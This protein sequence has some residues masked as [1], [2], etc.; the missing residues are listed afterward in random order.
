MAER[1]DLG[2]IKDVL[3]T[4]FKRYAKRFTQEVVEEIEQAYEEVYE[5]FMKSY[6]NWAK[7]SGKDYDKTRF[8]LKASNVYNDIGNGRG[9]QI[10]TSENDLFK[11]G[12]NVDSNNIRGEIFSRWGENK[13]E[14]YDKNAV[15]EMMF[16]HGI[17]GYNKKIVS[18]KWYITKES[19]RKYYIKYHLTGNPNRPSRQRILKNIYEANIIPPTSDILPFKEMNKRYK[20]ITTKKHLDSKWKEMSKDLDK[21]IEKLIEEKR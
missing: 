12:V 21:D 9:I 17:I 6:I 14:P 20:K 16:Y 18:K 10:D 2:R 8:L 1:T 15:F 7:S 3:N 4:Q 19:Q 11:S 5:E 13:G